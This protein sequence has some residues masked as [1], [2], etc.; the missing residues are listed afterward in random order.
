[1]LF[2]SLF[3]LILFIQIPGSGWSQVDVYSTGRSCFLW[4]LAGWSLKPN[5]Y[6][7]FL[8]AVILAKVSQNGLGDLSRFL[9]TVS[10]TVT[11]SWLPSLRMTIIYSSMDLGAD[12]NGIARLLHMLSSEFS[13]L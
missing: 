1:M 4:S 5:S 3:I 7:L 12:E 8:L 9:L 11:R 10:V 6:S 13:S 2:S